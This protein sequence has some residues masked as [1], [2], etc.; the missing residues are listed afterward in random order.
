MSDDTNVEFT[1]KER[2][3]L[4]EIHE[5][6][7]KPILPSNKPFIERMSS[8]VQTYERGSFIARAVLWLV[9]AL[10]A[11]VAVWDLVIAKLKALLI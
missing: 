6:L 10:I 8:V 2:E 4:R 5:A 3:M 9:P 7:F 11:F 1:H